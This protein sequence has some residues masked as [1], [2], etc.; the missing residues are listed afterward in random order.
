[1]QLGDLTL[2]RFLSV[3]FSKGLGLLGLGFSMY[4]VLDDIS[5]G[6]EVSSSVSRCRTFL[7][8]FESSMGFICGP[9]PSNKRRPPVT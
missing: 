5:I 1:M 6:A 4:K 2:L 7:S 8:I 3:A 9:K